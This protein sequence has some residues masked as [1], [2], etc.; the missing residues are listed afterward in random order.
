MT[1][2]LKETTQYNEVTQTEHIEEGF[3]INKIAFKNKADGFINLVVI[4]PFSLTYGKHTD[5]KSVFVWILSKW[6]GGEI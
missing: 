6:G 5:N 1:F 4:Y 3:K 2:S